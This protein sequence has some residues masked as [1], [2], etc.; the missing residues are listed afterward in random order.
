MGSSPEDAAIVNLIMSLAKSL[1][2]KVVAEGVETPEQQAQ[3]AALD[4]D[5]LQGYLFSNPIPASDFASR[6]QSF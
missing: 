4:C 2:L 6:L 3:L 5:L 1:K